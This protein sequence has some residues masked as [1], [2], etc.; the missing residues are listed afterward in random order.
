MDKTL[1]TLRHEMGV[2]QKTARLMEE[3]G[4]TAACYHAGKAEAFGFALKLLREQ[5]KHRPLDK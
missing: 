3:H 5:G 4:S 2:A 1:E